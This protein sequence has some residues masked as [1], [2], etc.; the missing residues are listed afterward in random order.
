MS[1]RPVH[2]VWDALARSRS[3]PSSGV[4]STTQAEYLDPRALEGLPV[5]LVGGR[6][7]RSAR[8]AVVSEGDPV[9]ADELTALGIDV[10][11]PD[12]EHALLRRLG[13][14]P[15][16]PT[17]AFDLALVHRIEAAT[18][19]DPDRAVAMLAAAAGLLARA[20]VAP[21]ELPALGRVP[22]PTDDDGWR[23]AS[24][25]L[26]PGSVL[27]DVVARSAPRLDRDLAAT[28]PPEG[29]AALGVLAQLTAVSVHDV[30]LDPAEWSDRVPDGDEWCGAMADLVGVTDPAALFA[31][32]VTFVRG[33]DLVE[34]LD[35]A[36]VARLLSPEPVYRALTERCVVLTDD[37]RRVEVP[38]PAAW[39][40]RETPLLDG[41]CPVDVRLP[42]DERLAPFF[43][44][45]R[46]PEGV[47]LELLEAIGVHTTL[48]RW[49]QTPD[50]VDELLDAMADPDV[51]V[52]AELAAAIYAQLTD[53]QLS[54]TRRRRSARP[55]RPD[56]R[57]SSVTPPSSSTPTTRSSP[58]RRTTPWSPWP[59][60]R[61]TCRGLRPS[62]R[63]ST[64]Q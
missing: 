13:A 27:D 62:L 63:C 54:R 15:F 6:L 29:W 39:W 26:L 19:D 46:A 36:D 1:T 55:A 37:G 45:V 10:V 25:V 8:A 17:S 50:G 11:H 5:P 42:G 35:W 24:T 51:D 20:G 40:L 52:T 48:D 28:S 57:H 44:L 12:A 61:R 38:S 31:P 23:P 53:V 59:R 60:G 4:R 18:E 47:S 32:E 14:V 2:E 30:V 56:P 9:A 58:L 33:I 16:S 22:V 41:R 34:G 21:G 49:L 3:P 43:P 64:S 7:L